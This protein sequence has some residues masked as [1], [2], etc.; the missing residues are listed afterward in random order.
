M[1]L[2]YEK[3]V[4]GRRGFKI[5]KSDVPHASPPEKR[6]LRQTMRLKRSM[7]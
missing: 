1:R 5:P 7:N 2:I 3:N 6:Y 4:E